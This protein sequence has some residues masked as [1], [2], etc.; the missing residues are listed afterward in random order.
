MK[1]V[2][3]GLLLGGVI[4]I[5]AIV[6]SEGVRQILRR[7]RDQEGV[8]ALKKNS[9]IPPALQA[10]FA[11]EGIVT[12]SQLLERTKTQSDR[13]DLALNV[14]TTAHHLKE[15]VTQADLMRLNGVNAEVVL[16]L[17]AAGITSCDALHLR[18]AQH[19]HAT[20]NELHTHQNSVK[21]LPT[22][23]QVTAWIA[24]AN[25]FALPPASSV[26]QE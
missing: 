13:V 14:G 25:E 16:L 2:V 15:L 5:G 10:K 18:N 11:A 26:S 21:S 12:V 8:R 7:R 4:S 24:E 19:L 3:K 1:N 20:L 23:K 22:L 9:M 17:E 6:G